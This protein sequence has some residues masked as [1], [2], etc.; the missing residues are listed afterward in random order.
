MSTTIVDHYAQN[1]EV[2]PR[3]LAGFALKGQ[4]VASVTVEDLSAVDEFHIG[5]VP[6]AL[7]LFKQLNIQPGHTVLDVGCGL[8]GPARV[9][10]TEH[11][12]R[13]TGVDITPEY[14]STGNTLSSWPSVALQDRVSLVVGDMAN[15][16][17]PSVSE[18][19]FDAGYMI[20]V[21]MVK[22]VQR[23]FPRLQQFVSL[24]F[25]FNAP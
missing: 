25:Y 16:V 5:G 4:T 24:L 22:S 21:G 14:V 9:C 13:V 6:A 8:G 11:D 1:D 23:L 2:L 20:H 3:I 18:G 19:A 12:C 17:S 15:V 7:L 10:A